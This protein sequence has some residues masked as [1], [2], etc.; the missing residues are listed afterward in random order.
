MLATVIS[1][2]M[3]MAAQQDPPLQD[4]PRQDPPETRVD[5][6]VVDGRPLRAVADEFVEN[7]GEAPRGRG[8]ARWYRPL[9]VGAVNL[10]PDVAQ[11]LLDHIAR[12]AE[13]LGVQSGDV[14]C[15]P[16]VI[17]VFTDDPR[18]VAGAMIEAD[19]KGFRLGGRTYHLSSDFRDEFVEGD[20]P[21]R[22]W[23]TSVP[24]DSETGQRA[25]RLPGDVDAEGNP[26]A[27]YIFSTSASRLNSQVRD[28]LARVYI[29]VD[30]NQVS[31]V[32]TR[33]L[34]DYLAFVAL[35]QVDPRGDVS[36]QA[37]VLNVFA[38]PASSPGF[39]DWDLAYLRALYRPGAPMRTAQ[40]AVAEGVAAEVARTIRN[41][42]AE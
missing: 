41:A 38:D 35:A 8:L 37:S 9:C 18:A 11:P 7:V 25:T 10:N 40:G 28:D 22:W 26:A 29:I 15:R 27:P 2:A 13:D 16:N 19:P 36:R 34:A 3:L 21:V 6:I 14:G 33:Q 20:R 24:V 30:V 42:P 23:T 17:M 4:P 39:S 12:V 1:L 5:D 32:S 31:G